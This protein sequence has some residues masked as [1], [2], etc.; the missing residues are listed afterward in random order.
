MKLLPLKKLQIFSIATSSLFVFNLA[1]AAVD[2][3]VLYLTKDTPA[4]YPGILF[5]IEKA[6]E[7]RKNIIET[8]TLR[9]VNESYAKSIRL[10]QDAIQLDDKKTKLLEDQNNKLSEALAMSKQENELQKTIWFTLGVLA[11]G[12]AFYGAKKITQ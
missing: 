6:A 2:D 7:I 3:N 8:D 12:F 5:P 1:F 11:T 4:P 9:A 10:Y